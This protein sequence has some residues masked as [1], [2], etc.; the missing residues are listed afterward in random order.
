MKIKH[1]IVRKFNDA[2]GAPLWKWA[3]VIFIIIAMPML[4]TFSDVM[5]TQQAIDVGDQEAATV[6]AGGN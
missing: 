5:Q 6:D 1:H 2:K 3:V 4:Y